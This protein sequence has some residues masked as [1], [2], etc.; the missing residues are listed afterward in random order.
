MINKYLSILFGNN[1]RTTISGFI[2]TLSI[3]AAAIALNPS[4]IAGIPEPYKSKLLLWAG[5][6]FTI[7]SLYKNSQT[8]D[9]KNLPPIISTTDVDNK[10]KL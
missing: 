1:Y 8:A 4:T 5:I 2:T 7:S 6:I 3:I 10:P 9:A